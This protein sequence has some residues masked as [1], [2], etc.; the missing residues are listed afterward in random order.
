M[1]LKFM[2]RSFQLTSTIGAH[3]NYLRT[4]GKV[5][6]LP[7]RKAPKK[8]IVEAYAKFAFQLKSLLRQRV[9]NKTAKFSFAQSA[10]ILPFIIFA[11][12]KA[13]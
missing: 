2:L 4:K 10:F 7:G 12:R 13:K 6:K 8:V 3:E 9:N 11:H 5:S 1:N